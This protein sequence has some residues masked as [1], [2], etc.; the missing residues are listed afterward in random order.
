MANHIKYILKINCTLFLFIHLNRYNND[1]NLMGKYQ[2][3]CLQGT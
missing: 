1:R 2:T 3:Q